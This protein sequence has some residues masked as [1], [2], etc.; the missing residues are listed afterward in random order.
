MRDFMGYVGLGLAVS[1][2]VVAVMPVVVA[3]SELYMEWAY[4]IIRRRVLK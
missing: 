1:I 3:L 2:A 4:K